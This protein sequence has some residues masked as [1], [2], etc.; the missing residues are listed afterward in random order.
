MKVRKKIIIMGYSD[1]YFNKFNAVPI[2]S[3]SAKLFKEGEHALIGISPFNG[4]FSAEKIKLII[5][6][7]KEHFKSFTV[8]YPDT[9]SAHTLAPM[10]Y[11]KEKIAEKVKRADINITNKI[12]NALTELEYSDSEIQRILVKF[13]QIQEHP[14]YLELLKT[15]KYKF[16][17]DKEVRDLCI[18]LAEA[19]VKNNGK[20][21]VADQ[22]KI[23]EAAMYI[24]KEC[25]FLLDIPT[26]FNVNSAVFIYHD[27]FIMSLLERMRL[28]A[29]LENINQGSLVLNIQSIEGELSQILDKID[30]NIFIK[31]TDHKYIFSN[32]S[33]LNLAGF[34]SKEEI[35]GKTDS[36]CSWSGSAEK[37][38]KAD[39]YV[40]ET[41]N[42]F[43]DKEIAKINDQE[44]YFISSKKP[45]YDHQNKI[46]G[47]IGV[48]MDVTEIK[49][50][51]IKAEQ[52]KAS[53]QFFITAMSHEMN[54]YAQAIQAAS[55]LLIENPQNQNI[56]DLSEIIFYASNKLTC[57]RENLYDFSKVLLSGEVLLKKNKEDVKTLLKKEID[58]YNTI[59]P[60]I[61]NGNKVIFHFAKEGFYE[62]VIDKYKIAQVIVNL[63]NNSVKVCR[64]TEIK[65]TID[66]LE[67]NKIK[68]ISILV[69]DKGPGISMSKESIFSFDKVRT[70]NKGG[71]GIGLPVCKSIINAHGG[72]LDIETSSNGTL[73]FIYFPEE[74]ISDSD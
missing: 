47:L 28:L 32:K 13:T 72:D 9:L 3:S 15:F 31:S 36:D 25:S 37:L 29:R 42:E 1:F 59:N 43:Y 50:A 53:K 45:L 30:A 17:H 70:N 20:D 52:E 61:L 46:I 33:N 65:V 21:V 68:Y 48:A 6:W 56:K 40:F 64:D 14:R 67:K 41:G 34:E 19:V 39:K 44:S 35:V 18:N 73:V 74:E 38:I 57:L 54:N 51:Q 58:I 22:E 8:F 60:M 10:G 26:I 5:K 11:T 55:K 63:L 27:V 4:Y 69:E 23:D 16:E 12:K 2:G 62:A 66:K 7:T 71:L 24:I 49:N